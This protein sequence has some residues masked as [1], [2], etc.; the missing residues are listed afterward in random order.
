MI[1]LATELLVEA[2][3]M[4]WPATLCFLRIGAAV[5]VLPGFGETGIPAR[6][7]LAIAIAFTSVVLPAVSIE[8][9]TGGHVLA[10][11]A[12]VV[13]GLVLGLALRLMILGLQIAAAIAAQSMSL[14]QLFA[15]A[16]AEPQPAL[17][18][19]LTLA[20]TALALEAGLHVKLSALFILSYDIFPAGRFPEGSDVLA[21][22]SGTISRVTALAFSLAL[23]FVVVG[24]LWN[25][26]LGVVN[27]AMPQ[28][29]VAFIGAPAL[30][31]GSLVLAAVILPVILT[32]WLSAF[33]LRL[34]DPFRLD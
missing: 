20:A 28:L 27:R 5:A 11:A 8:D 15:S 18:T 17:G 16:G 25:V 29:M 7:R 14:A 10:A 26:A 1:E 34:A 32:L 4:F 23:P 9:Q 12:N 21:W 33:D 19:I 13:V 2:Q 24:I 31:L 6:L 22:G 30:A 3:A